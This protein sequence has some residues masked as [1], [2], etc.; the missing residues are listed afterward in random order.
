MGNET[1]KMTTKEDLQ[2]WDDL[3]DEYEK[4][5]GLAKYAPDSLS[6]EELNTYLSM[7]RNELEK[8]SPEDCAQISYRLGQYSFHVQRTL[9]REL[10]RHNWADETIKETIADEINSYKGYGYLE[11]YYQAVKHNE[12]ASKLSSI[13]KYAKQ[14]SDRLSYLA[15]SIKGLSDILLNIQKTKVKHHGN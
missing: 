4:S 7:N 6:S 10:A 8:L 1:V 3:L 2:K 5:V 14:R 15:N 13:K 11:K 12:K 9:N